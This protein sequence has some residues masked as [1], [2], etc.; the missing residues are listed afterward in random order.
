MRLA[1]EC[2]SSLAAWRPRGHLGASHARSRHTCSAACPTRALARGMDFASR[3]PLRARRQGAPPLASALR[4]TAGAD[5]PG[6]EDQVFHLRRSRSPHLQARMHAH[7][8]AR[9]LT[10]KHTRAANPRI[11]NYN[12]LADSMHT[13]SD[14]LR[15]HIV[16]GYTQTR[17]GSYTALH[18]HA[19]TC[20]SDVLHAGV[21]QEQKHS[22]R[23]HTFDTQRRT[24]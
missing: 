6:H 18:A 12:R 16:S 11:T 8:R 23:A 17:T 19:R 15:R 2:L 10:H 9:A 3:Q 7:P 5:G 20:I 24:K 21:E 13:H 14:A 1:A 4:T 22:A